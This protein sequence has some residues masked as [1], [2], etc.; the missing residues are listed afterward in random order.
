MQCNRVFAAAAAQSQHGLQKRVSAAT[1]TAQLYQRHAQQLEEELVA[2]RSQVCHSQACTCKDVLHY[3][4]VGMGDSKAAARFYV[5]LHMVAH[6][7]WAPTFHVYRK[8]PACLFAQEHAAHVK[9]FV[10]DKQ[11][12]QQHCMLHDTA[13]C[14]AGLCAS[15]TLSAAVFA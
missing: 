3:A 12:G 15:H 8:Q 1:T 2:L 10:A 14:C 9:N 4:F 5:P 7:L 11:H 13:R 6:R